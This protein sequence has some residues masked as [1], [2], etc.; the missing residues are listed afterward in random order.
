MSIGIIFHVLLN[1]Y[2]ISL[3]SKLAFEAEP[4]WDRIEVNATTS[5]PNHPGGATMSKVCSIFSQLL[6]LFPRTEFERLVRET[7]A[8]RHARGVEGAGDA[9]QLSR[10]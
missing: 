6:Q 10:R 5:S 2:A 1:M 3:L 7:R 8:E 9:A 4:S